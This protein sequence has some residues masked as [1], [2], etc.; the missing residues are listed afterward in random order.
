MT[1]PRRLSTLCARH[2]ADGP[3]FSEQLPLLLH[4][5]LLVLLHLFQLDG[6]DRV[7]HEICVLFNGCLKLIDSIRC[8]GQ[9]V[10]QRTCAEHKGNSPGDDRYYLTVVH[11]NAYLDAIIAR[12]AVA[13]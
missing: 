4:D 11:P 10:V 6:C 1:C 9:H 12:A 3:D 8:R 2:L 13:R 5:D 7:A